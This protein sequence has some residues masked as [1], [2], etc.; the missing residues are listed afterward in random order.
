MADLR[1]MLESLGYDDV[2]THLQS[3]NAIFSA[4]PGKDATLEQQISAGIKATFGMEVAVMVRTA[5]R[6]RRLSTSNPFIARGVDTS[7]LHATFLVGD[8]TRREDRRRRPRC[9]RARRVRG[10]RPRDLRAV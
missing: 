6:L 5:R 7:E 2:R 9:V 8:A 4:G 1:A 3:G 10:R